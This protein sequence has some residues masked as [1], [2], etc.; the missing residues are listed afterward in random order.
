[1]LVPNPIT[2]TAQAKSYFF[3]KDNYYLSGEGQKFTQWW[4][5]GAKRLGLSGQVDPE[6]FQEL[7]EGRIDEHTQIGLRLDG[8]V[9]HRPG[10]DLT[11]MAPKSV[12][13]LGFIGG[14]QRICD[15]HMNAVKVSMGEVE[16]MC[17][18][19]KFSKKEGTIFENSNN[20]IAALFPHDTSRLLDPHMH[21]HAVVMNATLRSDGMW[22]ALA[23][24]M[25]Y[26]KL[27]GYME[28]VNA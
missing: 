3:E 22:R 9:S 23:S 19:A 6:R 13:I 2:S 8:T 27:N 14:D 28:R 5:N 21:T 1:M 20:L 18:R 24:E 25:G 16:R 12:S 7:L 17:A 4:G 26:D 11:F 15:A 10:S